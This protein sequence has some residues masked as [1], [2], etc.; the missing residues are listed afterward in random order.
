M[1]QSLTKIS[2]LVGFLNYG[3]DDKYRFDDLESRGKR[4]NKLETKIQ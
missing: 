4:N 2:A 1:D 3:G